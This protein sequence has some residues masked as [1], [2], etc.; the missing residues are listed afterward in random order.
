MPDDKCLTC[1]SARFKSAAVQVVKI[2]TKLQTVWLWAVA[3]GI[4]EGFAVEI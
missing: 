2:G 1:L 4:S 3:V